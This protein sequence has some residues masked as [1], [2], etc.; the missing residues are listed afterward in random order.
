M[1]AH[2]QL[3]S[4][5]LTLIHLERA[6]DLA[7]EP[8]RCEDANGTEHQQHGDAD[9][10]HVA[11]VEEVGDEHPGCIQRSEIERTEQEDVQRGGSWREEGEPPP[12]MIL[13]MKLG[14]HHQ[15]GD[16][17]ACQDEDEVHDEGES[18]DVVVLVH[19]QA[20]HDEEELD[21]GGGEWHDPG[22]ENSVGW[23][24]DWPRWRNG[25]CDGGRDGWELDG[26]LLVSEVCPEE[27]ERHGDSAPEQGEDGDC[28]DRH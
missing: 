11:E 20:G 8:Q 24:E 3:Y 15:H 2:D 7:H 26:I 25:T 5:L 16:H 21:V 18:E 22:H 1:H 10:E 27:D 12:S 9:E 17:G 28:H 13:G 4:T 23:V 14:V 6:V 19:P